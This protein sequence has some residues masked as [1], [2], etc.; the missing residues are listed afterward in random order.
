[1]KTILS[2]LF[3]LALSACSS[4]EAQQLGELH[5]S[6]VWS[7]ATPPGA[8]VAG[9]FLTIDNRGALP[10]RLL[11]VE[12]A[13]AQRV[14]IH[15]MSQSDGVARMRHLA[16][17]LSLPAKQVTELKSG[18]AHLMFIQPTQ[19]YVEGQSIPAVLVFEKAGSLSVSFHVQP[20][21]AA[22]H[23]AGKHH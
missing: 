10:D 3:V 16:N 9:G 13:A 19:P 2:A 8:P 23:N 6:E 15:E 17:G 4:P 7:K 18:G 5:V 12:S 1:M 11:R 21:A 14:E 20:M 22:S